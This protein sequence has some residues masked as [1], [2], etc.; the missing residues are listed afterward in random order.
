MIPVLSHKK[1]AAPMGSGTAD[2]RRRQKRRRPIPDVS[3]CKHGF[4][5][6]SAAAFQV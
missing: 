2:S 6:K 5:K 1:A 4:A 3:V